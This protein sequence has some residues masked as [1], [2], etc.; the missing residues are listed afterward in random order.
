MNLIDIL[1]HFLDDMYSNSFAS[2]IKA[3]TSITPRPKLLIDNVFYN[4]FNES[5]ISG[6]RISDIS[7]YLAQFIN[8]TKNLQQKTKKKKIINNVL[9]ILMKI[10]LKTIS[11]L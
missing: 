6:Y 10:Y 2:Y 9:K 1:A 5:I 11:K 4:N 7:D 8:T 3:P